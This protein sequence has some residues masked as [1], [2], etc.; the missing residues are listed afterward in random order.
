MNARE[1]LSLVNLKICKIYDRLNSYRHFPHLHEQSKRIQWGL[2]LEPLGMVPEVWS[3]MIPDQTF[4]FRLPNVNYIDNRFLFWSVVMP[5]FIEVFTLGKT[6]NWR[7]LELRLHWIE[8]LDTIFLWLLINKCFVNK[9]WLLWKNLFWD[10]LITW[11]Q[12]WVALWIYCYLP[13]RP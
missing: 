11:W 7:R 1:E 9:Y 2:Q 3:L 12:G 8:R 5:S 6:G 10:L 4:T 13:K